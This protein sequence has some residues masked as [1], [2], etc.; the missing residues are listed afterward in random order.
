M[1]DTIIGTTMSISLN[2]CRL[3]DERLQASNVDMTFDL[4]IDPSFSQA[5]QK[6]KLGLIRKWIDNILKNCIAFNVHSQIDTELL[7][8]VINPVMFCP[9]EPHDYMLL[10]LITAKLNAIGDGIVK[11]ES[12]MI[13]SDSNQGFGNNL[14][15]DPLDLLPTAEDWMGEPRYYQKPWWDRPDGGMMDL[16][17]EEGEDPMVKPDILI[18]LMPIDVEVV[19]DENEPAAVEEKEILDNEAGEIINLNSFKPKKK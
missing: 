8:Q 12:S 17:V 5:D 6:Q 2:I 11:V 9:D 10:L 4:E 7:G 15:G 19:F 13:S 3:V 16:P 18:N 14:V 1:N